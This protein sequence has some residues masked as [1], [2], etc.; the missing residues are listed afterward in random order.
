MKG[1]G[2]SKT[3]NRGRKI[4]ET[5]TDAGGDSMPGGK[6]LGLGRAHDGAGDD[7]GGWISNTHQATLWGI[8]QGKRG[9]AHLPPD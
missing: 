4:P 7:P 2:W 5:K 6:N 9:N 8:P 1:A 3:I